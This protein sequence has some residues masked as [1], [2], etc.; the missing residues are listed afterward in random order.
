[1]WSFRFE[2]L[3][4]RLCDALRLGI[5]ETFRERRASRPGLRTLRETL[6][7]PAKRDGFSS[8][9]SVTDPT[10]LDISGGPLIQ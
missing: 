5:P 6:A 3:A 4:L 8:Q 1:M 10:E 9:H 7:F 2:A